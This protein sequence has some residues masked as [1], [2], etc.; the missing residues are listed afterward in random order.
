ME[1]EKEPTLMIRRVEFG[2]RGPVSARA[3]VAKAREEF[4]RG[5]NC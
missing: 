4:P 3:R 2:E 5:V 1:T